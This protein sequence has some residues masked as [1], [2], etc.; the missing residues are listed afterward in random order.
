MS[1]LCRKEVATLFWRNN[2]I[3]TSLLRQ[4]SGGLGPADGIG[5]FKWCYKTWACKIQMKSL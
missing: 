2:D 5:H 3:I 1:L 4:V